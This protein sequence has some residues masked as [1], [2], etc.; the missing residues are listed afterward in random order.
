MF[1]KYLALITGLPNER[2]FTT[3]TLSSYLCLRIPNTLF[4]SYFLIKPLYAPT[5]YPVRATCRK[6]LFHHDWIT[7]SPIGDQ[8]KLQST[9]VCSFFIPRYFVPLG[10]KYL[11]QH[12]FSRTPSTSNF[13]FNNPILCVAPGI[14]K[15]TIISASMR[16]VI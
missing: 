12:S 13:V 8:Q 14:L 6:H 2:F 7:C 16:F 3:L 11:S 1:I 10:L 15:H 5:L 9:W 4:S